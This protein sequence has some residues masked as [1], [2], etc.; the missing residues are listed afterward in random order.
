MRKRHT[1]PHRSHCNLSALTRRSRGVL[2]ALLD[3]FI[4]RRCCGDRTSKSLR[5]YQ[6]AEGRRVCSNKRR[7]VAFY[8]ISPRCHGVACDRT[9]ITSAFCKFKNA[10]R[11]RHQCNKGLTVQNV[12]NT[13]FVA[14]D[15][16][17]YFSIVKQHHFSAVHGQT[18]CAKEYIIC[19]LVVLHIDCMFI[20]HKLCLTN[21]YALM[22]L[23]RNLNKPLIKQ[24]LRQF[25][26]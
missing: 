17:R 22:S 1:Q 21:F 13:V 18:I 12:V 11:A 20:Q 5:S 15:H 2:A 3:T 14:T 23:N 26:L 16:A 6:K 7:S 8:A 19:N 10:V 25:M 4:I 9:A 24:F